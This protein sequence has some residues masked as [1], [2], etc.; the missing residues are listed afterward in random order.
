VDDWTADVEALWKIVEAA[1]GK[2]LEGG[3]CELAMFVLAPG[4]GQ[5]VI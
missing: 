4:P 2:T 1:W 5:S 3:Y